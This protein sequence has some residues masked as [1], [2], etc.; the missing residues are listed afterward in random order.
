MNKVKVLQVEV[1][2]VQNIF[3]REYSIYIEH[4]FLFI[5]VKHYKIY[6]SPL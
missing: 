6:K 3:D 4:S 2:F 5:S 1:I